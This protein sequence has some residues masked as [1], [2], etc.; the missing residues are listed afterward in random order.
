M[1]GSE[2]KQFSITNTSCGTLTGEVT[3][4]CPEFDITPPTSYSLDPGEIQGFTVTYT[5]QDPGSDV[6]T[7]DTGNAVCGDVTCDATGPSDTECDV[8]PAALAFEVDTIGESQSKQFR[9]TN[10]GGGS[11]SGTVT[12]ACPEFDIAPP[13]SYNLG[14]GDD[15]TFIVTYTPEDSGDDVCLIQTGNALCGSVTCNADGPGQPLCDVSPV[16]LSFLVAG[17]G[18]SQS[19]QFM[20]TNTGTGT[21]SG[22]VT[23]PDSEFS[24]LSPVS[25]SLDEGQSQTFT[26]VYTSEDLGYD[27]CALETGDGLCIDVICEATCVTVVTG[28]SEAPPAFVL[29]DPVPN[30]VTDSVVMQIGLPHDDRVQMQVYTLDGRL[31]RRLV[32]RAM[33]RGWHA[34]KWDCSSE[35]GA[36]VAKGVYF[37]R[38]RYGSSERACK[39]L[40]LR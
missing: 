31:V 25:Y 35:S 11:L 28:V 20:I 17:V 29:R 32:D 26:V 2:S 5:P 30:P 4:S 16:S 22:T 24:I 38:A 19:S 23:S 40:V 7:I 34:V 36:G 37:V 18:G 12:E 10:T 33:P 8:A 1:G 6:C 14:S 3:E 27:V 21:L 39:V 15:Q 13:T 9:I